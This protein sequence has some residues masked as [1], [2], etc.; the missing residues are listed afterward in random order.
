[1]R[2]SRI[3]QMV[4]IARK[5]RSTSSHVI[6]GSPRRRAVPAIKQSNGSPT[7]PRPRASSMSSASNGLNAQARPQCQ[8]LTQFGVRHSNSPDLFEEDQ[9]HQHDTWN[10]DRR[11]PDFSRREQSP[12]LR[13]QLPIRSGQIPDQRVRV[14]TAFTAY[15]LSAM[16]CP[17]AGQPARAFA[18]AKRGKAH[19]APD[20]IHRDLF[21]SVNSPRKGRSLT[22]SGP[23]GAQRTTSTLPRRP[24]LTGG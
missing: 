18:T 1:V 11:S 19:E 24:I 3:Y 21:A 9:L 23:G 12:S 4:R 14:L 15:E 7:A 10:E 6:R 22:C 2:A 8:L 17:N 20:R 5:S 13:G 16:V